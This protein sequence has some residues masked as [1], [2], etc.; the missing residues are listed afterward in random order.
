MDT[1]SE[2]SVQFHKLG[3]DGPH[4]LELINTGLANGARNADL[5][6]RRGQ[7]VLDPGDRRV[8]DDISAYR[9][10]G[11][12]AQADRAED[13]GWRPGRRADDANRSSRRWPGVTDK[14]KRNQIGVALFG[15]QWEDLG[16]E[17]CTGDAPGDR[18]LSTRWRAPPRRWPTPSGDTASSRIESFKRQAMMGLGQVVSQYVLPPLE[19][20]MD[21][22]KEH[23]GTIK[24]LAGVLGGLAAAYLAVRAA[25]AA[26]HAIQII[27]NG[28]QVAYR[29]LL[30]VIRGVTVAYTAVQWLLNVAMMANPIG[31]IIIAIIALVAIFIVLWKKCAVVQGLL[32]G[33]LERHQGGCPRHLELPQGP[34]QADHDDHP[35]AS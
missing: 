13:R 2:Y 5:I 35:V 4:A 19:K 34:L 26:V 25:T 6:A 28:A 7:G 15:T 24:V 20:M 18:L 11:L 22:A 21:W 1:M 12:N 23:T 16:V 10:L 33:R 30:M 8:E 27:Y 3:I 31:L 29:G 14:V 32:E 9:G 17:G